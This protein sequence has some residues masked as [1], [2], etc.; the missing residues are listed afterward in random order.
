[1]LA[2]LPLYSRTLACMFCSGGVW[3][4]AC[5]V[6]Q[7]CQGGIKK[8]P[9]HLSRNSSCTCAC[10]PC[11]ACK[12]MG[13]LECAAGILSALKSPTEGELW[14]LSHAD[15]TWAGTHY[16]CI[17]PPTPPQRCAYM[18]LCVFEETQIGPWDFSSWV[19]WLCQ[20]DHYCGVQGQAAR[21]EG[22]D[23]SWVWIR[24][25]GSLMLT[26]FLPKRVPAIVKSFAITIISETGHP[27]G[28]DI[29]PPT[30]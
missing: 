14:V 23:T 15:T 18:C 24:D 7:V 6:G 2:G 1:M 26:S 19:F 20:G 28:Q 11:F 27:E 22:P 21:P 3:V 16:V 4:D 29:R 5:A 10:C 17:S 8:T 9:K 25:V 30:L 12:H 13:V